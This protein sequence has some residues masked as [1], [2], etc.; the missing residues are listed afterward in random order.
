[1]FWLDVA[2]LDAEAIP[3][4]QASGNITI[5]RPIGMQKMKECGKETTTKTKAQIK[6]LTI[7]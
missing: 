5:R 4:I 3:I 2:S 7:L 1:V 6:S